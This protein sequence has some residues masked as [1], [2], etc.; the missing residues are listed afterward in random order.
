MPLPCLQRRLLRRR[1]GRAGRLAIS[2]SSVVVTACRASGA[3]ATPGGMRH[4]QDG[5]TGA[6]AV[7]VPAIGRLLW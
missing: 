7:H 4:W 1:A 6:R 3:G 2:G 5:K